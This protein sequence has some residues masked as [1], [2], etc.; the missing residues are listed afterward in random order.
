M[1]WDGIVGAQESPSIK[2][3][4]PPT[5]RN[6][7][8][9]KYVYCREIDGVSAVESIIRRKLERPSQILDPGHTGSGDEIGWWHTM[10]P[11]CARIVPT[12]CCSDLMKGS[13]SNRHRSIA[14]LEEPLRERT[15]MVVLAD[16]LPGLGWISFVLRPRT[17]NN[18]PKPVRFYEFSNQ[19]IKD[20]E[21]VK[22]V[23]CLFDDSKKELIT[24]GFVWRRIISNVS[25]LLNSLIKNTQ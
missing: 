24:S 8:K 16:P 13:V 20:T 5:P 6:E 2:L 23:V 21:P 25:E 15:R 10:L 1:E 19:L 18:C 9:Q 22:T 12:P 3:G 7:G 14:V 11:V 17:R 4:S